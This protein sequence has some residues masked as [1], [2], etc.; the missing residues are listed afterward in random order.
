MSLLYC[1][2]PSYDM[3]TDVLRSDVVFHV[4]PLC[5]GRVVLITWLLY[6]SSTPG[7]CSR[8]R[9]FRVERRRYRIVVERVHR[10]RASFG[11]NCDVVPVPREPFYW[12]R[13]WTVCSSVIT[14][15]SALLCGY[16]TGTRRNHCYSVRTHLAE[17]STSFRLSPWSYRVR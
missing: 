12:A 17:I 7:S 2:V 5:Y 9:D 16:P 3:M 10:F 11:A 4:M 13:V 15:R 1:A 6:K 14:E 8:A